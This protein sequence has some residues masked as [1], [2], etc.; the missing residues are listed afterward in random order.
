VFDVCRMASAKK[1]EKAEKLR[2]LTEGLDLI[3]APVSEDAKR[4]REK[5]E[6]RQTR[7]D[8]MD[9]E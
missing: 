5:L 4:I 9:V 6:S 1:H 2:E 8:E 7:E 3:K